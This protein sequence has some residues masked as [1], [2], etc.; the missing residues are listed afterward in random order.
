[1]YH[2][3]MDV[4]TSNIRAYLTKDHLVLD[5]CNRSLGMKDVSIAGNNSVLMDALKQLYETLLK[6]CVLSDADIEDIWLSGMV[7]H[8]LGICEVPH[9]S[10]PVD[11]K[12]MFNEA[13]RYYE[14][15]YF[16]RELILIRGVKTIQEGETPS[17]DTIEMVNNMRGEEI[18][19]IGLIGSGFVPKHAAFAVV[20]PGSHTH[21]LYIQ[22]GAIC[23]VIS[24]FTGELHHAIASAT[25]LAG[26]LSPDDI[27]L[28][29]VYVK[30]GFE[31]LKKNG[32]CRALYNLH[33]A[34]VFHV[35][36]NEVRSQMMAGII[37]GGVAQM[38]AKSI[39]TQWMD[40]SKVFVLGEKAHIAAYA[41][42]IQQELPELPVEL[43]K[44]IDGKSFA[45]CGYLELLK[46]K[47]MMKAKEK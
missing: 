23:D 11:A 15:Q 33:A 31:Y 38:L 13:C 43:I 18:E 26:E 2:V 6:K 42:L 25:I 46:I 14:K 40:V 47:N 24:N 16:K 4:G 5:T 30:K 17:L 39:R 1:M 34:S 21:V 3:Y 44:N 12:K 7:T 9:M 28:E 29:P 19:T 10:V 41:I 32:M 22:N 36:T 37:A 8:T 27:E 20:A 45:L 35:C